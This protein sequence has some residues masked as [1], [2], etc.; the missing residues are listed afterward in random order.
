MPELLLGWSRACFSSISVVRLRLRLPEA[1]RTAG[2]FRSEPRPRSALAL[3]RA[4]LIVQAL[5]AAFLGIALG[6]H[7]AAVGLIGL[8]VIVLATVFA[9]V[10]EEHRL[11]HAFQE[12]LPFTAYYSCFSRS[13]PSSTTRACFSRSS[14]PCS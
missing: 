1:V 6:F 11:G 10:T 7:L 8:G 14:M 5:V 13:S 9:G 12:A 4:I 2:E 3:H